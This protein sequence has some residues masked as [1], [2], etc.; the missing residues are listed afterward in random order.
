MSGMLIIGAGLAG[1]TVA[2]TL[3]SE[4]YAGPITLIGDEAHAPY[5]RPPLSKGFLLGQTAEAQLMMRPPELLVKKDIDLRVGAGATAIDR[6]TKRVALGDGS[7]LG[8]DGLALCPGSRLRPLPLAGADWHGVYGLRTLDEAKAIA[9]ALEAAHN[10]VIIGGGFIGL[11]V[12]SVARRKE[13][14][15]TVLEAADRL[16]ARVVAPLISQFYLDLHTRHGAEVVLG[17]MVSE[18]VGSGG[19]IT[20]VRTR[21]GRE[22][23]ADLVLVGIGIIPNVELAQAAGLEVNGGIVVDACGRCSDPTIVAA[24]DC[25]ARRLDDGSLRRLESV[26]NALEQGRSAA[27]ALLGRDRPFHAAPWFWSDQYDVKL[28][29]LGLTA[30]FDQ[31]VTRGDPTTQ[32]FSAYYYQAGKLIAIDSLNQPPEHM[33]GRKLFEKGISP[34]PAQAADTA[35]DL[36]SLLA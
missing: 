29:M 12:A 31:V 13:K 30:G 4:G 22:F 25:T 27:A 21:D 11:E 1:L 3:R 10:V 8:Y 32:K 26:Q 16:M 24:G 5:Q 17:A 20:A 36:G 23:P 18:L 9:A 15:V 7:T 28:Q 2:E 19:R 14:R 6:S 34:T 33:N 35:F